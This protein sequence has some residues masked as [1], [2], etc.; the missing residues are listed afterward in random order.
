MPPDSPRS[1]APPRATTRSARCRCTRHVETPDRIGPRSIGNESPTLRGPHPGRPSR[2]GSPARTICRQGGGSRCPSRSKVCCPRLDIGNKV[3]RRRDARWARDQDRAARDRGSGRCWSAPAWTP[4]TRRT[5]TRG[6]QPQQGIDRG[7]SEATGRREVVSPWRRPTSS[8]STAGV[9]A[10]ARP[11]ASRNASRSS[12]AADWLRTGGR[13]NAEP[14]RHPARPVI[15]NAAEPAR[16][17]R[18]RHRRPDGSGDARH[19]VMTALV[20]RERLAS[21]RRNASTWPMSFLRP[22]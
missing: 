7:R 8:S 19:G 22:R 3:G 9:A 5:G 16:R 13:R 4:A 6:Q 20:A 12:T 2:R 1:L 10:S 17:H 18:R 15:M 14:P 21:A 11:R